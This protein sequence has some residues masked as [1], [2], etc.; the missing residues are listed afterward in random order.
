MGFM[1]H[2]QRVNSLLV[3]GYLT[4][5]HP[6]LSVADIPV[7]SSLSYAPNIIH[8]EDGRISGATKLAGYA[9]RWRVRIGDY[10]VIYQIDDQAQ[11]VT[12]LRIAHRREAYR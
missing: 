2:S 4:M 1:L 3:E 9:N 11:E 12:V 10:R 5:K 6:K 8:D 7:P